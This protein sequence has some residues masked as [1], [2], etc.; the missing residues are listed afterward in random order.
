MSQER[1]IG[2]SLDSITGSPL[3]RFGRGL[4]TSVLT[5][6]GLLAIPSLIPLAI[7]IDGRQVESAREYVDSLHLVPI[8]IITD[9]E[10][11][12][13]GRQPRPGYNPTNPIPSVVQRGMESI[14]FREAG[15]N[16]RYVFELATQ[17]LLESPGN[18]DP[19]N[20]QYRLEFENPSDY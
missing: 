16:P 18:E 11:T 20:P 12:D 6:A 2:R 9:V 4:K 14:S 1:F 17:R 13:G 3:E 19:M 5:V 10:A 7:Y 8:K 15:L